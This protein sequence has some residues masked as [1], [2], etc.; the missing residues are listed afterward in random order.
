VTYRCVVAWLA[1]VL[2]GGCLVVGLLHLAR[3]LLLRTDVAGEASHAVMGLGMAAMF[4][5]LGN[6]VPE[7]VWTAVFLLC[8]AWF[9]VLA[10][11]ARQV[12]GPA[13]HH[14]VCSGAMLFM[15]VGGHAHGTGAALG[16][17]SVAAIVLAGYFAWHVLRCVD[18]L[19]AAKD[20]VER[21]STAVRTSVL[22][23]PR[24]AATA[25]LATALMMTVML[26]GM[27]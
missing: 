11:R 10:A 27:I 9:A 3:M 5:P 18:H 24:T 20:L 15:L 22:R 26:I 23:A 16:A 19:R 2:T 14:V 4:S 7:P 25:H 1:V 17:G 6:P 13:G 8:A 21:G 12:H